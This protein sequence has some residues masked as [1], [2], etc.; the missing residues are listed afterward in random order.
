MPFQKGNP[1]GGRPKGAT[2]KFTRDM[3][4]AFIEAFNEI[5]GTAALVEW[6]K[7]G[8]HKAIF[9]QLI[10]KLLPRSMDVHAEGE[11]TIEQIV[12]IMDGV[13]DTSDGKAAK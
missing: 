12:R 8:K 7:D 9:Y 10:A 11:L 6:A 3:A 13:N 1:G 4:T 2:N 5:G